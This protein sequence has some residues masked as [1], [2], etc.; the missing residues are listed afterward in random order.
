MVYKAARR[1]PPRPTAAAAEADEAL[2]TAALTIAGRRARRCTASP[3]VIGRSKDCD[4]RLSDPNVSRRHAEVRPDGRR[5]HARRP[6]LDERHRGRR[7]AREGARARR[8]RALHDRLD[9]DRL[10]A[11]RIAVVL[12]RLGRSRDN[13]PRPQDRLPRPALPLHLADRALGLARPAPAAGVDDPLAAAGLRAARRSPWRASSAGSSSS[14][15][16]AL[17]GGRRRTRSTRSR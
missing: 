7:Q 1:R 8:R 12:D 6:R 4:I 9:R 17:D 14:T 5:L 10:L 16:P 2:P 3:V 11:R 15:S 13:P